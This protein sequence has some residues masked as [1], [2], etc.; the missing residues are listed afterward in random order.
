MPYPHVLL[1]VG[2]GGID[3]HVFKVEG[4]KQHLEMVDDKVLKLQSQHGLTA[5]ELV[6]ARKCESIF[7][8]KGRGNNSSRP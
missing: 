3:E 5:L 1:P 6:K 8:D 7:V 4:R 2:G